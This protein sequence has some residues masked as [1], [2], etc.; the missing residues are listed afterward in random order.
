MYWFEIKKLINCSLNFGN[1]KIMLLIYICDFLK[2]Y[3]R[4]LSLFSKI[5]SHH[6]I[7]SEIRFCLKNYSSYLIIHK[8]KKTFLSTVVLFLYQIRWTEISRSEQQIQTPKLVFHGN[9]MLI[10]TTPTG[11]GPSIPSV[12]FCLTAYTYILNLVD[13]FSFQTLEERYYIFITIQQCFTL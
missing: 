7:F 3:I 11:Y 6:D 5:I 4:S 2:F 10:T 13:L 8:C 12:L 1:L 9:R